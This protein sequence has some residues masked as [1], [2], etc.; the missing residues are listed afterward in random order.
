MEQYIVNVIMISVLGIFAI[1]DIRKR[2]LGIW[3]VIAVMFAAVL[4]RGY[5]IYIAG[6]TWAQ[7]LEA[8]VFILVLSA[9]AFCKMIGVGDVAV[10]LAINMAKGFVFAFSAF[11]IAITA[12]SVISILL[13]CLRRIGR[14]HSMPLVPYICVSCMGVILCG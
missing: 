12:V 10:M 7:V 3:Q 13:L 8:G 9:A 11:A 6:I 5:C 1:E 4:Y 2:S 14:K